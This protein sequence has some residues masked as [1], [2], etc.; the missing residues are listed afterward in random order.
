MFV[1]AKLNPG[2]KYVQGMNEI[3]API[4]YQFATD[5]DT[6]AAMHAEADAFFCFVELISEFR[7]HFCQHLVSK[8]FMPSCLLSTGSTCSVYT[9]VEIVISSWTSTIRCI[10]CATC[11]TTVLL[12]LGL[13]LPSSTAGFRHMTQSFGLTLS[14]KPR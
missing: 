13:Q 7:D 10:R 6:G 1:Y 12:A 8:H 14:R 4:Y 5:A 9:S 11:R 2:I 3:Y